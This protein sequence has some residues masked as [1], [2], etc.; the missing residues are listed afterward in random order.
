MRLSSGRAR[1]ENRPAKFAMKAGDL[2]ALQKSVE[3]AA[4]VSIGFWLSYLFT[5][6]YLRIAAGGITHRDL[7]LENPVKLPFLNIDFRTEGSDDD[8]RP[9][10]NILRSLARSQIE[11]VVIAAK[12]IGCRV[13]SRASPIRSSPI[14]TRSAGCCFTVCRRIQPGRERRN[15]VTGAGGHLQ[16]CFGLRQA[17]CFD[18]GSIF[19][20]AHF[21]LRDLNARPSRPRW[22]ARGGGVYPK[23]AFALPG[24][25]LQRTWPNRKATSQ[26]DPKRTFNDLSRSSVKRSISVRS[27]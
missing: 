18:R 2:D 12:V 20:W 4:S 23:A 6:F 10:V 5:L 1:A 22:S 14:S 13:T 9:R 26:F 25:A 19:G 7:L 16:P 24:S 15:F 3:E 17:Q 8:S 27:S 11:Q 21:C